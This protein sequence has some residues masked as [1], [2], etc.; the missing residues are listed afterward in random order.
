MTTPRPDGPPRD[1]VLFVHW[2]DLGRYLGAYHHADVSSPRLDQLA[3]EGILFTRAHATAPLCSPSRGSLFTGRYPQ[4]NGLLGLAH[5][6]WEYRADVRTLPALLSESGWHTALFGM[7][8]ET[9]YPARLGFDEF[10]VSNSY[11][12]Y[13]VERAVAWL[14]GRASAPGHPEPFLLTTGFFETHRPY[15]AERYDPADP[16]GV[17]VPDY[18]PDTPDIRQDLADF[19]GSITVADAAVGELLDTLA[20]TGLDRSTWVVFLTDH[21]PALPR[22]KSTLYDAGTGIAL[23]VRPPLEA[24]IAPRVYDD[25][26]SGVDLTPTLLDLLSV[27]IPTEVQGLSHADNLRAAAGDEVRTEVY[28]TKT[29]H[30]S[31]D[32][33]RAIR[34]K[35]YSYIENYTAR[36]LLDLP[37]DIADSPPGQAVGPLVAAPRPERELYDLT[38]DPTETRN[39][40]TESATDSDVRAAEEIAGDLALK[41]DDWRHKTNDVIP[42]DFAGSRISERYTQTYLSIHGRPVTSRSGIAAD[43]GIDGERSGKTNTHDE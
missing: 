35:E 7:Q 4:S 8:H 21:G 25:L 17:D 43:R 19:Y 9:S 23:I 3:A 6:G 37:W 5:H 39:L 18:L 29:Y 1:N 30:D 22:A 28:T 36:P 13:V 12:E 32:P 38:A 42:S 15:P 27:P 41:L 20:E 31:F 10:D 40:L 26:F 2:H 24:N 14:K 33:I 11:C 34:T 16:A